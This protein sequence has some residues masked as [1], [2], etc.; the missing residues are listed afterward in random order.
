MASKPCFKPMNAGFHGGGILP[1]PPTLS[2]SNDRTN[3]WLWR[4]TLVVLTKYS[5]NRISRASCQANCYATV[6]HLI[7][8]TVTFG[9][10][11]RAAIRCLSTHTGLKYGLL[12]GFPFSSIVCL[13]LEL[14]CLK[15]FVE[16]LIPISGANTTPPSM[17]SYRRSGG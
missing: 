9:A 6:S 17:I 8:S 7:S 13:S 4:F 12:T 10:L 1:H 2:I 3:S 14:S 15:I 11:I 16:I 5:L